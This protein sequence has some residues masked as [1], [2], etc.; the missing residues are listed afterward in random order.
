VLALT[1]GLAVTCFTM[2]ATSTLLGLPR[3]REVTGS[4]R[5]PVSVTVPMTLLIIVCFALG[6]WATGVIPV[7][8]RITAPLTGVDAT[9]K[10]VPAFFGQPS[11][12]AADV[13]H[14]LTQLGAQLGR[15]LLPLRGLVV[16]HSDAPR[17][18]VVYA[19]STALTF[20]VLAFM[21]LVVWVLTRVLRRRRRAVRR[22]PWNAGIPGLRPDMT[23]TP[24]TFAAPVRVLFDA[25]LNPEVARQEQRQGA[26][27][28]ARKQQVVHVHMFDRL[29]VSP[30]IGGM[31]STAGLLARMHRGKVTVYAGY[32]LVSLVVV[33]L[34]AAITLSS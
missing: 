9:A 24:T 11:A 34:A 16:L 14:D 5:M 22:L 21:L 17:A 4:R 8:G 30:L 19:M 23:Y 10:L 18:G 28:T 27:V 13:V 1:A 3:S 2:L 20:A 7:L 31:Q 25:V 29:L 6:V 26:F 33:T 15:G 12:L 32:V